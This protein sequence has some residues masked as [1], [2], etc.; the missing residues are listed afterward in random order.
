MSKAI[1]AD[2][3]QE[4]TG[5]TAVL[6]NKAATAAIDA[7]TTHLRADGKFTLPSFG[8]FHMRDLPARTVSNPRTGE[9]LKVKASKSVGF[10]PSKTLRAGVAGRKKT[11]PA[12]SRGGLKTT[13]KLPTKRKASMKAVIAS[14]AR[15]RKPAA[16][17]QTEV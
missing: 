12:R 5:V 10:K 17:A 2:A 4:K 9:K 16:E 6:A 1:I 13:G 15:G 14:K 11:A 3:I 8:T 7:I